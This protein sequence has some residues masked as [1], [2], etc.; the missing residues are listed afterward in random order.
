MDL[1]RSLLDDSGPLIVVLDC[2]TACVADCNEAQCRAS[3]RTREQLV[4]QPVR[5]VHVSF[6]LR[7]AEQWNYFIS[8]VEA[9]PWLTIDTQYRRADGSPYPVRV[10]CSVH[11][12]DGRRYMLVVG[13]PVPG[14]PVIQSHFERETQ[15]QKALYQMATHPAISGGRIT[16]AAGFIASTG[17]NV[18]P[19]NFC[20]IWRLD[21]GQVLFVADH[22]GPVRAGLEQPIDLAVF[23]W[24]E[25]ALHTGRCTD[26]YDT[27]RTA[28][29]REHT[30]E[31]AAGFG[32]KAVLCAPIR[33]GGRIWGAL[34]I[35][36]KSERVRQPDEIGFAAELA[37]QVAYAV[38]SEELRTS[39][40]RY[41]SFVEMSAEA[42]WRVEFTEPVD[43]ALPVDQQAA[44]VIAQGYIADCNEAFGRFF[45]KPREEFVGMPLGALLAPIDEMRMAEIRQMVEAG[46]RI[47][48]LEARH[49][50][51]DGDRW[52]LRN[53]TGVVEDGR[54][55]SLWGASRDITGRKRAEQLLTES[56]QR[57]RAF[58]ANS[59]EGIFRVEYPEPISLDLPLHEIVRRTWDTGVLAECNEVLARMRGY[60]KPE[61][62]VGRLS[63]EFRMRTDEEWQQD[64]EFLRQGCR[65]VDMERVTRRADGTQAWFSYSVI[66]VVEKGRL[67]RIWGRVTD[68]TARHE[69]EEELRALSARRAS[70]L[71]QERSR[72]AREIHDELGQQLTALKFEAAAWERGKRQPR[73][74]ALTTSIDAAIQTVRRIATGLRPAILDHFGLVAAI[75]WLSGEVSQRTGIECDCELE[76]GLEVDQGL[77]TTVFRI[78]QEALTNAARHSEAKLVL[79][80][81]RTAGGRL[82]LTVQDNGRGLE[83][84][85]SREASPSLGLIGMRERAKEAGGAVNITGVPGQGTRVAA[86]FPLASV[87]AGT[88]EV[89]S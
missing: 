10:E 22:G 26:L 4:G 40:E 85:L 62:L 32:A 28:E 75:E 72:I 55:I 70:I 66:G 69:L 64:L 36:N 82:E 39:R 88:M 17:Q 59:S 79:V 38:S 21:G 35:G 84:G 61:E 12:R 81:L 57:Y 46:Y 30:R 63:I 7:T 68:T 19:A 2:E 71:E 47:V 86:W 77:A 1:I 41:R 48:N 58:V 60:R 89:R 27:C 44:A 50:T 56:E 87:A 73:K 3:G 42:V 31:L 9:E 6:P 52:A 16:E 76:A 54:L 67:A 65:I 78:F 5:E 34:T 45:S 37:D 51:D 15:W 53:V 83:G 29:E 23:Q 20:T 43:L 80:Q 49:H 25:A 13:R 33:A 11:E 74:G 14:T 18:F 24:L 8:R